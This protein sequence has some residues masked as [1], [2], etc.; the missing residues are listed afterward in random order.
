MKLVTAIKVLE[1]DADF[2]GM[3]FVDF[4]K[5]VKINPLA[6]PAKTVEAYKVFVNES[7]KLFA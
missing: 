2:L 5:F 4:I 1:K 6:Q 7:T 3:S